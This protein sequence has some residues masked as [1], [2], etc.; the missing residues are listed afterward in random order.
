MGVMEVKDLANYTW[1]LSF[2]CNEIALNVTP[3][4]II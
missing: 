2:T 3:W 4:K 1:K